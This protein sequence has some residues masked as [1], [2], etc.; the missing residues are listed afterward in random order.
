MTEEQDVENMSDDELM[1]QLYGSP[2]EPTKDSTLKLFRDILKSDDSKKIAN[3][4]KIDLRKVRS[5]IHLSNYADVE[6]LDDVSKYLAKKAETELAT[7]MSH[8]GF[9]AQLLVTQIKKEQKIK[10]TPQEKKG[11]SLFGPKKESVEN[12]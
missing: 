11:W 9:F 10:D 3:L 8:K 6:G 12:E 7:S 2:S 5:F 4:D 1:Q